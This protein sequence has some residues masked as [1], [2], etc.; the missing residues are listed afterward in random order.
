MGDMLVVGL[1]M[2]GHT[3]KSYAPVIPQE[4]R[5]EM[6]ESLRCVDAVRLCSNSLEALDYWEPDIFCKGYDRLITGLLPEEKEYCFKHGIEVRYTKKTDIH[7]S[8]IIRRIRQ[9]E[10]A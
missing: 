6:L 7:T 2:D 5:K 9:C 4:Q 1:T 8:Q 3:G 10:F